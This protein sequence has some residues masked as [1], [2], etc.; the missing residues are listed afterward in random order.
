MT[1]IAREIAAGFGHAI[2]LEQLALLAEFED[3]DEAVNRLMNDFCNR[4]TGQHVAE[5]IRQERAEAAEHERLVAQLTADGYAVTEQLPPNA[6][7]LHALLHDGQELT[8]EAHAACPGRGVYFGPYQPL[9][10]CH[11]C[12]DPEAN[13]HASRYQ[14]TPLP[15][16]SA[17]AAPSSGAADRRPAPDREPP[18]AHPT[19]SASSSSR[20]TGPGSPPATSA[21]GGWPTA[22]SPAA[23]RPKEAMPFITAQLLTMPAGA[24]R[25]ASPARPGRSC[26][27]SSPAGPSS[28]DE[29]DAWPAG[30]LPL[31]LLAV[32][33][34]AYEDRMDGDAGRAT[35]RTDRRYTQCNRD[36]A[37]TYFRFLA[38]RRLRTVAH[39]AGRRR[40]RSL[41]RRQH[42]RGLHQCGR[43]P[44]GR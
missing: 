6:F 44:R 33:A 30:R 37:G 38:L 36:D 43:A 35:W 1:G 4:R 28:R 23:P 27:A 41:H 42:Q 18:P 12:T 11:Y 39:R 13:G 25:R 24:A 2:T 26:S 9:E 10:P 31:A 40:R 14:S 7:M 19:R 8:P 34:A 17:T 15:D 16:L 32:I 21:S 22:C 29:T 3:D 20:A 5:Q